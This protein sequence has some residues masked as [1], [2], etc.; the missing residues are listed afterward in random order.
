M[1]FCRAR[2]YQGFF[3]FSVYSHN[4]GRLQ[5]YLHYCILLLRL[6]VSLRGGWPTSKASSSI[7][8]HCTDHRRHWHWPCPQVISPDYLVGTRQSSLLGQPRFNLRNKTEV[9]FANWW[10][11]IWHLS[12]IKNLEADFDHT[13]RSIY[14]RFACFWTWSQMSL[15]AE[16]QA[17]AWVKA[18]CFACP[19]FGSESASEGDWQLWNLVRLP[20]RASCALPACLSHLVVLIHILDLSLESCVSWL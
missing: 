17:M 2:G 8:R 5:S 7:P 15:L 12:L 13:S 11:D 16:D 3:F 1:G 18:S 20:R 9:Q 6:M 14:A 4:Q 10:G 19:A